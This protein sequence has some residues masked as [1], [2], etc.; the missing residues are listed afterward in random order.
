LALP[1]RLL[2]VRC[3]HA[4]PLMQDQQAREL[5]SSS[6]RM[7][8]C[9]AA[10]SRWRRWPGGRIVKMTQVLAPGHY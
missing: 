6:T 4:P 2:E 7:P 5:A 10:K 3:E 9:A 8:N 1:K